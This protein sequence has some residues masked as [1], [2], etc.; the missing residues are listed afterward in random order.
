[1]RHRISNRIINLAISLLVAAV[2]FLSYLFAKLIGWHPRKKCV[3]FVY[4]SVSNSQRNRFAAQMEVLVRHSRPVP[5]DIP[6]LSDEAN[7]YAAVTFDDGI[8][9]IIE[10]ALPEL[11]KRNIPATIFVVSDMLGGSP[12][13]EY[14]GANSTLQEKAMSEA[15][16]RGLPTDLV[17]IG[18]HTATHPFLPLITDKT[19]LRNELYGSRIKLEKMLGREIKLFS[20]PYGEFNERVITA[21]REAGYERVFSALPF[22]SFRTAN[23]FVCGRVGAAPT[24]W[25]I[26]FRLKLAGAYRW[27]PYAYKL[28][29]Q[30]FPAS[31][32]HATNQRQ[33]DEREKIAA[34]SQQ[35]SAR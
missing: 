11:R 17:T 28:K 14:R 30:I 13:W 16:L 5:A 6:V 3:V 24:D 2:D 23:E 25:P 20:S 29:R 35:I 26:E 33:A 27:V 12:G 9:N 8:E 22:L 31:G 18:S 21:C 1:M 34:S 10:N 19:F 15:Q 7:H 4:H 32:Q